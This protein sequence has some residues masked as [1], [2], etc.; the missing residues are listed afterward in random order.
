MGNNNASNA[1]TFDTVRDIYDKCIDIRRFG[2][3]TL[4]L[5]YVAAGRAGLFFEASLSLWDYAAGA[6]IIEE[7]GGTVCDFEGRPLPYD[8]SKPSVLAGTRETVAESGI[9]NSG[10]PV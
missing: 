4:D 5:C 6:I 2:A 7:A 9:I 3:A 8:L 10:Y 1:F